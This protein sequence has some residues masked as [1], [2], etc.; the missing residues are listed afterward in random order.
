MNA[1][2]KSCTR[3]NKMTTPRPLKVIP[4]NKKYT[5]DLTQFQKDK[6]LSSIVL[7]LL[8]FNVEVVVVVHIEFGCPACLKLCKVVK[9]C[10]C[11][12]YFRLCCVG[13]FNSI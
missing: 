9:K 3:V 8:F 11:F 6:N 12:G 5:L 4:S 1:I 10:G 2:L 13:S 7:E